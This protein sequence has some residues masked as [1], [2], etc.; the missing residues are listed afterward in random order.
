MPIYEYRCLA[1]QR[2]F[3]A[4]QKVGEAPLSTCRL[5]GRNKLEKL[6]SS[7]AVV[8]HDGERGTSNGPVLEREP[9]L[10]ID[11]T[12]PR[13]FTH[14]NMGFRPVVGGELP[15]TEVTKAKKKG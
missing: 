11:A 1:C 10:G 2:T 7:F 4:L 14:P 3:E 8:V 9:C 6:F 15:K 5:C 12:V 13:T